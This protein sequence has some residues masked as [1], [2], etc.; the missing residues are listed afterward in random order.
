MLTIVIFTSGRYNYLYQLLNDLSKLKVSI[1]IVDFN[2]KEIKRKE[3]Q[4]IKKN[5]IKLILNDKCS[6]Y[7]ER[8]IKYINLI[9]T[10]YVWFI[11]DDD[12]VESSYLKKLFLILKKKNYSGFTLGYETF[13]KE[14]SIKKKNQLNKIKSQ[15]LNIYKD[16]HNLGMLSTQIINTKNYKMVAKD[17]NYKNLIKNIYPQTDIIIKIINRFNNWQKIDN[18]IVYYRIENFSLSKKNLLNRLDGEFK[19]YLLPLKQEYNSK[20]VAILYKK[21]FFKNTLSWIV[22]CIINLGK[23]ETFKVIK[24]NIKIIPFVFYIYFI[25]AI[26]FIMPINVILIIKK[27][28][29]KFKF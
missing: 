23:K 18:T 16:I 13:L 21:V 5:K 20:N 3:Y 22:Y 19:G 8:F 28:K 7:S 12:R 6:A 15:H 10:K 26:I 17:L 1:W 9:K 4:N 14:P 25:L 27:I 11:S 24:S 29:K 2:K